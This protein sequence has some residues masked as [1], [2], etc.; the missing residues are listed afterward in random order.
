MAKP[1]AEAE[2]LAR[3]TYGARVAES[4]GDKRFLTDTLLR[5]TIG[6]FNPDRVSLS[7]L[8]RMRRDPIIKMALFYTKAL[9][10]RATWTI[11]CEDPAIAAGTTE[12]VQRI[13]QPWMRTALNCLDFGYQGAVKQ[14]ELG[15]L[16]ST[17][18]DPETGE[19]QPVWPDPDIQPVLMAAPVPI[20]PEYAKVVEKDGHFIG[21]NSTLSESKN[22]SGPE[23]PDIPAD[24]AL[25]F[26]NEFEEEFHN[27][28]GVSRILPAYEAW[29]AY[30]FAHHMR[31][32]N[33]E[34]D[35]D[36]ALQVWYP[37]GTYTD[38]ADIDEETGKPRV[39]SN[40]A[41]ALEIGASL[42]GGA[43]IAWPSDVHVD[44]QGRATPTP[45]WRAEFLKG[46]ENLGAFND[47][48]ADL[49]VEK[50]RACLVPEQ[51]LIEAIG[52]TSSRNSAETYISLFTESM[53]MVSNVLDHQWTE[54][55]IRPFVEANWGAD[56]PP[57]IKKTTGFQAEDLTLATELIKQAFNLDPNALPIKFEEL[58]KSANLPVYTKAEQEERDGEVEKQKADALAQ[59]Q[60][61]MAAQG[62]GD[63]NDPN[64]QGPPQGSPPGGGQQL[65]LGTQMT[66]PVSMA[67]GWAKREG[68]RRDRNIQALAERLLDVSVARYEATFAAA[69]DEIAG[70]GDVHVEGVNLDVRDD[71]KALAATL[72]RKVGEAVKRVVDVFRAPLTGEMAGIYHASGLSEL[73]RLG[74]SADSWDIGREDVQR[75][76][77][78]HAGDLIVTID[79]TVVDQHVR[80]WLEKRLSQELGD[81]SPS[82]T[83]REQGIPI[84]SV[85]MAQDFSDHFKGYPQWMA[86]RVVRTEARSGYNLAA[87]DIWERVGIQEVQEFDGLGGRSGKT[88]EECLR[89]NGQ[90]VTLDQFRED[91]AE[92]H[93]NGTLGGIPVLATARL[94]QL[95][96]PGLLRENA[97]ISASIYGVT[98]DGLILSESEVGRAMAE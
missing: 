40:K 82:P 28:Y 12:A 34:Q 15:Q 32:R 59:Q 75:W 70:I 83:D 68:Q 1:N 60:E 21:I 11:E 20:P 94:T 69:S 4:L 31:S 79:R 53:E 56:A 43:T 54:Y 10:T 46:G 39:K 89:R 47:V 52:G 58:L 49:R 13:Y 38:P 37:P 84:N 55:Q 19:Q 76:A 26:T 35:A 29:H 3:G 45:L 14:Y 18:E 97:F 92:E 78:E 86:E 66:S 67:P 91:N 42:R 57:V 22:N 96:D 7:D 77:E 71:I 73:N 16:H 88:D 87:A 33:I 6:D 64:A 80:P 98:G 63:P 2:R 50:M 61:A 30:W 65:S 25:W 51:A 27:Y 90:T 72:A 8:R 93:P 62:G 81:Y 41:A 9:L 48:M 85:Q 74:L 95:D 17:Y 36:P 5:N 44:D 24:W 23:T